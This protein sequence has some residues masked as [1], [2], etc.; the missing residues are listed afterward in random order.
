MK[1]SE[2]LTFDEPEEDEHDELGLSLTQA[3]Q[4][5]QLTQQAGPVLRPL[6]LH[7]CNLGQFLKRKKNVKKR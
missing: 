1:M 5:V 4:R 6:P 7:I 3:T 2:W